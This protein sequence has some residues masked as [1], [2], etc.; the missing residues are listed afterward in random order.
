ML[1]ARVGHRIIEA[2]DPVLL[3]GG[4]V[5][6]LPESIGHWTAESEPP[7]KVCVALL[8]GA[9]IGYLRHHGVCP[10]TL[11]SGAATA[12]EAADQTL[13]VAAGPVGPSTRSTT[14]RSHTGVG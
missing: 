8:P 10:V 2:S 12:D 3:T 14:W 5:A 11:V 4:E 1:D 7:L 13:A 9:T 6:L